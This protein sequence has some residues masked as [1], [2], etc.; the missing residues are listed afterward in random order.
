MPLPGTPDSVDEDI[1]PADNIININ[2]ISNRASI[3]LNK[4]N[5]KIF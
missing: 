5:R 2:T 3:Y 1:A 4:K